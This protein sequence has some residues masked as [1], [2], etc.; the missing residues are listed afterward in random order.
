M[1]NVKKG[2]GKSSIP[3]ILQEPDF[4]LRMPPETIEHAV[5]GASGKAKMNF[6]HPPLAPGQTYE[7]GENV[8]HKAV[9][10]AHGMPTGA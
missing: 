8:K 4:E 3:E 7:D 5:S 1:S 6:K 10:G 9:T 2:G